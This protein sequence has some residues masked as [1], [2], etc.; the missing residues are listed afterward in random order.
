MASIF[1]DAEGF[2]E[3]YLKYYWGRVL[4]RMET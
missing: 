1:E 4:A 2:R 3:F